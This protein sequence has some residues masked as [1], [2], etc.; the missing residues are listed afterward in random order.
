MHDGDDTI[1]DPGAP[2][3][4]PGAAPPPGT[5]PAP[6]AGAAP[7]PPPATPSPPPPVASD[8]STWSLPA[9]PPT[10]PL[11]VGP[12]SDQP[13]PAG[14]WAPPSPPAPSDP[15]GWAPPSG[16]PPPPSPPA[17]PGWSGPSSTPPP[18]GP[19]LQ[20][21]PLPTYAGAG[22]EPPPPPGAPVTKGRSRAALAIL[23]VTAVLAATTFAVVALTR[24]DGAGS[25]EEAVEG[26]FAA[27]EDEDA[28][29][30][31]E[32]LPPGERD[33]LLDPMV[34]TV[35]ELQ[36]L[37]LLGSFELE[38]VPGADITVDGLA[39]QSTNLG[40]GITKVRVTGGSITGT[41][42]PD[43]VPI[44]PRARD[45]AQREGEE[46][47]IPAE[48]ET[49]SL[50]D[51]DLELVAIEEDG[52]W[53]VS[54]FYTIA[55]YARGDDTPLPQFGSGA[56]APIG[57]DTPEGAVRGLVE[58]GLSLDLG[59]VIGHLPPDE[60][61]VLYDYMPLVLDEANQ[62][63]DEARADGYEASLNRLD[64]HAE[65]DGDT[66]RV[67]IDGLAVNGG[68]DE[69]SITYSWDGSCT[70]TEFTGPAYGR[71][72]P[73]DE[74][75][76]FS[77][78]EPSGSSTT[79]IEACTD[80]R[81]TV[82]EDGEEVSQDDLFGPFGGAT[83]S[84]PFGVM[85][86][87]G[88][89][90]NLGQ[91][92]TVVEVDGRWYVSP[93]RTVFDSML[94]AMRGV[95]GE[96][97]D[98]FFEDMDS[99]FGTG[100]GGTFEPI[101]G[102][103]GTIPRTGGTIP[104][105]DPDDP[106]LVCSEQWLD[107]LDPDATDEEW[108]AAYEEF[109]QCLED[110]GEAPFEV[111]MT[112]DEPRVVGSSVLVLTPEGVSGFD[113]DGNPTWDAPVCDYPSWA[114]MLPGTS[115][116][117]EVA[118]CGDELIGI[119]AATGSELWSIDADMIANHTR[120]GTKHLVQAN[121]DELIVTDLAT[122][123]T[124]WQVDFL[125]DT[126]VA[127]DDTTVYTATD[128]GIGAIDLERGEPRWSNA[129]RTTGI[130]MANGVLIVRS[131]QH[132]VQRL[133]PATGAVLWTSEVDDTSLD[134]SDVIAFSSGVVI[135]KGTR[136]TRPISAYDL[137]TGAQVWVIEDSADVAEV[138]ASPASATVAATDHGSCDI[139]LFDGRTG[140][141][142]S[143]PAAIERCATSATI[144]AGRLVVTTVDDAS[145]EF[146]VEVLPVP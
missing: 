74:D 25:A 5:W 54:L 128:H 94:S 106:Y 129:G 61:R 90:A 124:T 108:D 32:S 36:R 78:P 135:F 8:P 27:I 109:E 139:E 138:S 115:T 141:A 146:L 122:G 143:T 28:I 1:G 23:S 63:A 16:P 95:E 91:T 42:I 2:R 86:P 58:A 102:N 6:P 26:L 62:E 83:G 89:N 79:R 64:L 113:L 120:V 3:P 105:I 93:M 130:G 65:G 57:A 33:V 20:G 71:F 29:G 140:P 34:A 118:D 12:S 145:G 123:A 104:A 22:A 52:G 134:A 131:D 72:A 125:G 98:R 10:A 111:P 117:V 101:P 38:D 50:A 92:V 48:T 116:E 39:L 69:Q 40:P 44:G 97:I 136:G 15:G 47:D 19:V 87:F 31:M 17:G 56:I 55:E 99:W 37:G 144:G 14:G 103:G 96:D 85:S 13:P 49:E 11:P 24:P 84:G 35:A 4:E 73:I 7:P 112:Y 88:T 30:V 75:G 137:E 81:V 110:A 127:S 100:P 82:T 119:D 132:Y 53:H 126:S 41:V 70:V 18:A 76:G 133:D 80:G 77:E 43:Q 67:V 142:A 66:R 68:A 107:D 45:L 21:A 59:R 9:T 46:I 51:A 121:A 114:A 60:M